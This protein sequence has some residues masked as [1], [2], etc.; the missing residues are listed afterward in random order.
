MDGG[1]GGRG[2]DDGWMEEVVEEDGVV[3]GW[4]KWWRRMGWGMEEVVEED[5]MMDG[6]DGKKD[7]QD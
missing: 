2:L 6:R 4:K 1:S 3:D 7:G 5:G